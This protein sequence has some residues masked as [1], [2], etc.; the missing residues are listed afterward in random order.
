MRKSLMILL[1][2]LLALMAIVALAADPYAVGDDAPAATPWGKLYADSI[3]TAAGDIR[4]MG[5]GGGVSAVDVIANGDATFYLY[6]VADDS[7]IARKWGPFKLRD[8]MGARNP[9]PNLSN[10]DLI[11]VTEMTAT[12]IVVTPHN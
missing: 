9:V 10:V 6:A 1:T 8:W 4:F 3:M 12:E 5:D 11:Q 7:T 2:A